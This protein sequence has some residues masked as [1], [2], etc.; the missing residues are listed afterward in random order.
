MTEYEKFLEGTIDHIFDSLLEAKYEDQYLELEK[1]IKK[2]WKE[3][4]K[5]KEKNNV[6]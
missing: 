4:R 5:V 1:F 2:T 3:I 6:R